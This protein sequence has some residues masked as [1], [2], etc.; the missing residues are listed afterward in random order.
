MKDQST[1]R[2][3]GHALKTTKPRRWRPRNEN[4]KG[5]DKAEEEDRGDDRDHA[6][7]NRADSVNGRPRPLGRGFVV[8][9]SWYI[10]AKVDPL[11]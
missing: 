4:E 11:P 9:C 8:P 3:E 6:I 1:Q 2:S 10:V 5:G 7:H